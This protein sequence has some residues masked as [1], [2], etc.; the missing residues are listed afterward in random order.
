MAIT[1]TDYSNI[2][3]YAQANTK[4]ASTYGREA[5]EEAM[6][7][8]A[9]DGAQ[10]AETDYSAFARMLK[11]AEGAA[12][13]EAYQSA[14]K[15]KPSQPEPTAKA[16]DV[17]KSANQARL[18]ELVKS[19]QAEGLSHYEALSKAMDERPDLAET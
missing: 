19:K 12:I 18:D 16:G 14:S 17:S 3:K 9:R 7:K 13:Y 5:L 10:P 15:P 2:R 6:W 8:L 1:S 4:I 11:T